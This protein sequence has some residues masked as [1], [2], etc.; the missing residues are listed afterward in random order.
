MKPTN[1]F[2]D[3][4]GNILTKVIV[5]KND[6]EITFVCVDGKRYKQYHEQEGGETVI[7]QDING[8]IEDLIGTSILMADEVDN[9]N[10]EEVY[11]KAYKKNRKLRDEPHWNWVFYKIA[12]VKGYVD[13]RWCTESNGYYSERVDFTLIN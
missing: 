1:D 6:H 7:I 2:S 10:F 8:D 9:E 3:L 13:I 12:T 11:E 4:V 5:D